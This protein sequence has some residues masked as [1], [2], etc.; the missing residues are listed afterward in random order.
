MGSGHCWA[1][2]W[3]HS[4]CP[5]YPAAAAGHGARQCP[6]CLPWRARGAPSPAALPTAVPTSPPPLLQMGPSMRWGEWVR[7]PLPR[8]WSVSMSQR[9]TTGSPCPPCPPPATGLPPS[10]RATRSSSWVGASG[11][12][13]AS[14]CTPALPLCCL[15]A[16]GSDL[17]HPRVAPRHPPTPSLQPAG[18]ILLAE[19]AN[20]AG[21]GIVWSVCRGPSGQAACHRL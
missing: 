4:P 1:Q 5:G 10:C 19:P 2:A 9:R 15:L 13:R 20:G 12:N 21:S 8:R 3:P 14:P 17:V 16:P 11:A 18:S 7:T 6:C